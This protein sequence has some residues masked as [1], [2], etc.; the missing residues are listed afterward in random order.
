MQ[1]G[2]STI[3][4]VLLAL[5]AC[6][7]SPMAPNGGDMS[8]VDSDLATPG[9]LQAQRDLAT[10]DLATPDLATPVTPVT[11]NCTADHWCTVRPTPQADPLLA[12][13][14][15]TD[16]D[17]WA[18]GG[19]ADN[20]GFD[21]PVIVHWDGVAATESYPPLGYNQRLTS[22]WASATDDAW[23]G[24]YDGVIHWN[25]SAWQVALSATGT[26][27]IGGTARDDVWAVGT[28]GYARHFDATSWS[29]TLLGGNLRGVYAASTTRAW[30]VADE[31]I[32]VWNGTA[33]AQLSYPGVAFTAISGRN[34]SDVWSVAAG[35]FAYHW[36]GASWTRYSV[37]G[38][39]DLATISVDAGGDAWAMTTYPANFYHWNGTTWS[40]VSAFVDDRASVASSTTAASVWIGDRD[41]SIFHYDGSGFAQKTADT[42]GANFVAI[43]GCDANNVWAVGYLFTAGWT[44]LNWDGANWNTITPPSSTPPTGV[45]CESKTSVYATTLGGSVQHW[46]GLA[47]TPVASRSSTG[48]LTAIHG[49]NG[50][51]WAVG[52]GGATLHWDGKAWQ[53][54][55]TASFKDTLTSVYV[56]ESGYPWATAGATLGSALRWDGVTWRAGFS[57]AQPLM[58]ITANGSDTWAGGMAQNPLAHF[59]GIS[60]TSSAAPFA[61]TVFGVTSA[62]ASR[63]WA[64]GGLGL[65]YRW[66]GSVWTSQQSGTTRSL[67][68]VWA[69]SDVDVWAVGGNSTILRHVP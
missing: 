27:A 49:R 9:D 29:G 10:L 23:A 46:D 21:L 34:D 64:V 63:A 47:W 8:V 41:G 44:V 33:W 30:V 18:V 60:W 5:T 11:P 52:A 19:D 17:V 48:E 15:R 22:V 26:T 55:S 66:D 42:G 32:H 57:A 53:D 54:L 43:H 65:I 38:A 2:T 61:Q 31:T 24:S 12:I 7:N 39:A 68:A 51:V 67:T 56:P 6:A 35:G 37:T 16:S 58:S 4:S 1:A 50:E 45:F 14:A 13:Y 28:D 20:T 3:L 36:D 69:A 25:G 59:D 62:L 40:A